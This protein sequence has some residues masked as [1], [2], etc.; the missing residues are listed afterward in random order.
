MRLSEYRS[1]QRYQEILQESNIKIDQSVR[2]FRGEVFRRHQDQ[3]MPFKKALESSFRDLGI[4][5]QLKK[6]LQ[7]ATVRSTLAGFGFDPDITINEQLLDPLQHVTNSRPWDRSGLT[8]SQLTTG[9]S[10]ETLKS[11][12]DNV[13]RAISQKEIVEEL[14]L[15]L[16]EGYGYGTK[17]VF[18]KR[19]KGKNGGF[20]DLNLVKKQEVNKQL[21]ALAQAKINGKKLPNVDKIT[22]KMR[23]YINQRRTSPLRAAYNEL[24]D[25]VEKGSKQ[26]LDEAMRTAIEEKTRFFAKRIAYTET[27]RAAHLGRM[28]R[29]ANDPLCV[30]FRFKLSPLHEIYDICDII[31]RSNCGLG[32][33][34]Y[35]KKNAPVLP[36]HPFGQSRLMPIYGA[37][38]MEQSNADINGGF[39]TTLKKDL[40]G[41]KKN[42]KQ[43]MSAGQL[44]AL[45]TGTMPAL[46]SYPSFASPATQIARVH[47]YGAADALRDVSAMNPG[48]RM[49]EPKNASEILAAGKSDLQHVLRKVP[50]VAYTRGRFAD[51]FGDG[52]PVPRADDKLALRVAR[53]RTF[54]GQISEYNRVKT[55][56]TAD[57]KLAISRALQVQIAQAI[58]EDGL[59]KKL[60]LGNY[61]T[62]IQDL[63]AVADESVELYA[64][65]IPAVEFFLR[66]NLSGEMKPT[67][68]IKKISYSGSAETSSYA[69]GNIKWSGAADALIHEYTHHIQQSLPTERMMDSFSV[70]AD[71]LRQRT[72]KIVK[73]DVVIFR[74]TKYGYRKEKDSFFEADAGFLQ[75]YPGRL[76]EGEYRLA[77]SGEYLFSDTLMGEEV[78]T[79]GVRYLFTTPEKF[80]LEDP[81]HFLI[82]RALLTGEF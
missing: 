5:G 61:K 34:V 38:Q 47:F 37:D 2:L 68:R 4:D 76:Y 27:E 80:I 35:S 62:K 40:A 57:G 12:Q 58:E 7:D 65:N 28:T 14:A 63:V 74:K 81:E 32:E 19:I 31:A 29:V 18:G 69:R 43:V 53:K 72:K 78:F 66:Q 39:F 70:T 54:S 42:M 9:G 64:K 71:F 41:G 24:L 59:L 8:L 79:E 36:I 33:G 67:K 26:K 45:K 56:L 11:I 75:E 51:M 30:G 50:P 22:A 52:G 21:E 49:F 23:R 10:K 17:V 1:W 3:G 55:S 16:Y 44:E 15:D 73:K 46:Y 77:P 20:Q 6:T 82:T 48:K 13:A 25:A 60:G